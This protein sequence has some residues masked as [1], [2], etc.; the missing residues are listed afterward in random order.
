MQ[1]LYTLRRYGIEYA[2]IYQL[3]RPYDTPANALFGDGLALR[4]YSVR[5][6]SGTLV[7]TPS[8]DVRRDQPGGVFLFVHILADDGRR[9][10]QVDA[11]I[12]EGMFAGWQAGQQFGAPLPIALP[13]DLAP[14][15]YRVA[16][17][18]YRAAD[19]ARLPLGQA[20]ALPAEVDG[21]DALLL[22]TLTVR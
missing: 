16:L 17:G 7:I 8:W 21:P 2:T 18:A 19:G 3:P 10:A 20:A 6:A 15:R 14:G 22:T 4:G 9:V 1:P 11:P 5:Q 13:P 12:D